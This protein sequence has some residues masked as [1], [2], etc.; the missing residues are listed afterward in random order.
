MVED[1]KQVRQR[2]WGRSKGCGLALSLACLI[3]APALAQT[4]TASDTGG[5]L[6]L[7]GLK[8]PTAPEAPQA[9]PVAEPAPAQGAT[10]LFPDLLPS[11][12]TDY[13]A[14]VR[15]AGFRDPV[16]VRHS[17]GRYRVDLVQGALLQSYISDPT[18]GTLTVLSAAGTNRLALVFPGGPDSLSQ[19]ALPLEEARLTPGTRLKVM[20]GSTVGRRPCTLK[21]YTGHLGRNGIMCVTREGLIL[22]MTP[23][24]R[25]SP[26]FQ[27]ETLSLTRQEPRWFAVPPDYQLT[28]AP[29][30][31]GA[32]TPR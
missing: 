21:S 9:A 15:L 4:A 30:M 5:R 12:T 17:G 31:G 32:R 27:V 1:R 29:A 19:I 22:Q 16:T 3:A 23:Q 26:V 8:S 13:V 7:R 24:G 14:T 18:R 6:T 20:G 28:V 10:T 2:F 11:S 25:K